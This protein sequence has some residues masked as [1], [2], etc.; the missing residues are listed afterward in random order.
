[1]QGLYTLP[2]IQKTKHHTKMKQTKHNKDYGWTME[3]VSGR[4]TVSGH[5]L[6]FDLFLDGKDNFKS[7]EIVRMYNFYIYILMPT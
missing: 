3:L 1:M 5:L 2:S 4:H 7:K 6:I